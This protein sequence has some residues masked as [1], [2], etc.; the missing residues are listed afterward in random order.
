MIDSTSLLFF[1][2][3]LLSC[4]IPFLKKPKRNIYLRPARFW[5]LVGTQE[6]PVVLLATQG[7][8]II[9]HC[10][11]FPYHGILFHT[12]LG[13]AESGRPSDVIII[14]TGRDFTLS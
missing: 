3:V 10:Y 14:K 12:D 9:K 2:V 1:V 6:K 13:Q 11:V 7:L 4:G 8:P 5:E